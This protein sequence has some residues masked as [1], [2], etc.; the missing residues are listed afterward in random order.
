MLPGG[1]PVRRTVPRL[2]LAAFGLA[3]WALPGLLLPRFSGMFTDSLV[4][5]MSGI[6]LLVLALIA[7]QAPA[8]RFRSAGFR[9]SLTFTACLL[10]V[11][12]VFFISGGPG[13]AGDPAGA[14]L[15]ILA[16]L[17][18]YALHEEMVFRLFL[19]DVLSIG[20]RF[21]AGALLSS[22]LFA[23]VHMDNPH[24]SPLGLVNI[25][26]AGFGLCLIRARGGGMAGAV[27]AHFLWNA[28]TG[29]LMG[30]EVSGF[31]FP[32]VFRPAVAKGAF[33]PESSPFVTL[34]LAAMVIPAAWKW[35]RGDI[36][37]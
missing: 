9:W 1:L 4:S 24:S 37:G 33:G 34:A 6:P 5:V 11:P 19:A 18:L 15:L 16:A 7:V 8:N 20:N 29:V 28:G 13:A 17:A 23:A 32:A 2:L 27:A 36:R 35:R 3:A 21:M 14:V 12:A 10:A 25:F 30:L 31:T 22:A 26:M